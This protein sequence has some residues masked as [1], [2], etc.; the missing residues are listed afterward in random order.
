[1]ATK[2]RIVLDANILIRAVLGQKVREKIEMFAPTVQF[3]T[4]DLCYADAQK[5]LPFLFEKRN[6]STDEV[7][8]VLNR[9]TCLIQLVDRSLYNM[10]EV[11]L[12][13]N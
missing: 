13:L 2:K 4:P 12:A 7:L 11:E 10:Y 5:Y 1:M 9:L 3:F 8:E 6:L